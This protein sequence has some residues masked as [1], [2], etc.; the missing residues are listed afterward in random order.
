MLLL[1]PDAG[2]VC[3]VTPTGVQLWIADD[4][5]G[6]VLDMIAWPDRTY[7]KWPDHPRW[8]ALGEGGHA[9]VVGFPGGFSLWKRAGMSSPSAPLRVVS[10]SNDK[11]KQRS[12]VSDAGGSIPSSPALTPDG[13]WLAWADG[14]V[15]KLFDVSK[16]DG[17]QEE[18]VPT[19]LVERGEEYAVP[20]AGEHGRSSMNAVALSSDARW[21]AAACWDGTVR[22]WDLQDLQ[23][24]LDRLAVPAVRA[25]A[26]AQ[27]P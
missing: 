16:L 1:S 9:G 15:V 20:S 22:V 8:G 6:S 26:V 17:K 13:R 23:R 7:P 5:G 12:F 4:P 24:V 27:G 25:P 10:G 11:M 18:Q 21:L 3:L 2:L 19:V 14:G